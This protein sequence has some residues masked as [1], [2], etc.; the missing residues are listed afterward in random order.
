[1]NERFGNE[2]VKILE[3]IYFAI[4]ENMIEPIINLES[5]EENVGLTGT[6]ANQ[7]NSGLLSACE[8][9]S[10]YTEIN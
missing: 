8:I 4:K 5:G 1:M 3:R 2:F 9:I 6:K 7:I 10:L